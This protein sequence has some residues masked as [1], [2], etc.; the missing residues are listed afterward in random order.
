[1]TISPRISRISTLSEELEN[2][3]I[4]SE[5]LE[6]IQTI[7]VVDTIVEVE[8]TEEPTITMRILFYGAGEAGDDR[9]EPLTQRPH[10][11]INTTRNTEVVTSPSD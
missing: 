2:K 8:I 3:P 5:D 10:T 1:M 6:I 11:T 7:V 4:D 9:T